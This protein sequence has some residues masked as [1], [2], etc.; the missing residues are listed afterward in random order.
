MQDKSFFHYKTNP[1]FFEPPADNHLTMKKGF[2]VS[3]AILFIWP[4]FSLDLPESLY[5][6]WEGKDRYVFF[7]KSQTDENPSLVILLKEYY[8]WYLDRAAE[9]ESYAQK[10]ARSRNAASPRKAEQVSVTFEPISR[11]DSLSGRAG[12]LVL[13]FSRWQKNRIAIAIVDEKIYL[14]FFIQD[15][16]DKNYYRGNA[17]SDGIKISPQPKDENIGG[18]YIT[19]DGIYDVRYWLSEMDY[20]EEKALVKDFYVD[21][22]L[23]SCGNNYSATSGRSNKV[24]NVVAPMPY[25]EENYI[26]SDDKKI[27]ITDKEP[28]LTRL[29]DR[30]TFEDLMQIVMEANSRVKA[31]AKPPFP[32]AN[33][34]WHWDLI[35]QLE[36]GN[37]IIEQVRQRQKDFGLRGKDL[38]R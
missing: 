5:G 19:S 3:L 30:E 34:D 13:D 24:R 1:T 16:E 2:L 11:A 21:K 7:E 17:S 25:N 14:N 15:E 28:Y 10:E 33:L 12:E 37:L 27:I 35:D 8:G 29:A 32:P 22:H 18:L 31:P 6:I 4:V 23:Y 38:G 36:K 26:F 20:S 9:P